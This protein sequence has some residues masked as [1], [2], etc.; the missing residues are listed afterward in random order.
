M[1][2]KDNQ[3]VSIDAIIEKKTKELM[4]NI[5]QY[6]NIGSIIDLIKKNN[7]DISKIGN[8]AGYDYYLIP[9]TAKKLSLMQKYTTI[10]KNLFEEAGNYSCEFKVIEKEIVKPIIYITNEHVQKKAIVNG[11]EVVTNSIQQINNLARDKDG[12]IIFHKENEIIGYTCKIN[13]IKENLILTGSSYI[14]DLGDIKNLNQK[15]L[16][17]KKQAFKNCL[18]FSKYAKLV[19]IYD[20]SDKEI[21]DNSKK[22]EVIPEIKNVNDFKDNNKIEGGNK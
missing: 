5:A 3:L 22:E 8:D 4:P 10:A 14:E 17:L 20:E 7:I 9:L 19:E 18:R 2:E 16:M 6:E 15:N 11:K 12:N 13:L 21:I 1:G